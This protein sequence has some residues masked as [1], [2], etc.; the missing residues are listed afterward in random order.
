MWRASITCAAGQG[1][2]LLFLTGPDNPDGN[3]L[4]PAGHH[5]ACCAC[6]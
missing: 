2:K 1:A 3:L 4:D 6:H 5:A